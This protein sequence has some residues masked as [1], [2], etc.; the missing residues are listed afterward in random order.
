M[1]SDVREI[2]GEMPL[3]QVSHFYRFPGAEYETQL[4]GNR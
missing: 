3:Q 4:Q 2:Q 1:M